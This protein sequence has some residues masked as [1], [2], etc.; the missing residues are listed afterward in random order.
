MKE[1]YFENVKKL[2][3]LI[4]DVDPEIAAHVVCRFIGELHVDEETPKMSLSFAKQT[5]N[6]LTGE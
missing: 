2:C 3:I 4:K 5:L 6:E 1:D